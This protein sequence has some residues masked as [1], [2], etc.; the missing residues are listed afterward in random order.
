MPYYP[1]PRGIQPQREESSLDKLPS[2]VKRGYTQSIAGMA[3]QLATG[4]AQF[5]L[6]DYGVPTLEKIGAGIVSVL[7]DSPAFIA[8]G[9]VGGLALKAGAKQ[10]IKVGTK[11]LIQ[12]K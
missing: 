3:Q 2:F 7:L 5:D 4:E 10:A 12:S 8:G 11:K 1:K 9:G 6:K